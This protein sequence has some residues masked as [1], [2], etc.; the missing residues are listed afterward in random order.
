[1]FFLSQVSSAQI[2]FQKTYGGSGGGRYEQG[3]SVITTFDN[4]Y[5]MSGISQNNVDD[6]SDI[7][8]VKTDSIGSLLWTKRIGGIS[9]EVGKD[10]KQTGD[11]G[12]IITGYTYSYGAGNSDLF[13]LKTD[14]NG[15]TMWAKT[16]GGINSDNGNSVCQ[17][18][19]GGYIA[20]GTTASFGASNHSDVYIVKTD[21][22]G[23]TL[24]TRAY[25]GTYY[26]EGYSIQ[27]TADS[28]YI[29]SGFTFSFNEDIYLIK[30]NSSGNLL[31][32]RNIGGSNYDYGF[33]VKQTSDGGYIILGQTLSFGTVSD[34]YLVKT[35]SLGNLNWSKT[36]GG[37]YSAFGFTVEQT[38][39][40]GYIISGKWTDTH[41]FGCLIKTNVFGDTVWTRE[42]GI[43]GSQIYSSVKTHDNGYVASGAYSYGGRAYLL[44]T[45]AQGNSNC[46]EHYP[47]MTVSIPPTQQSTPNTIVSYTNTLVGYSPFQVSSLSN[48]FDICFSNN[49]IEFSETITQLI[50]YLSPYINSLTLSFS[51]LETS[52]LQLTLYDI[53]GRIILQQNITS[54]PGINKKE[55]PFGNLAQGVYVVTLSGAG[56]SMSRKVVKE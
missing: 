17:T 10:I 54:I 49:V 53:T 36:F 27:Q 6:S 1:M 35:N 41:D 14:I 40:M 9:N 5:V 7:Y 8:L 20:V 48:Q 30:I 12:F 3:Y 16:Y 34:I 33:V 29:I 21:S 42:Y 50:T 43:N 19:D 44:K 56:G 39:N 46:Y 25:G 28:G 52:N 18:F 26:D 15:D 51:S 55:I 4:G 37:T 38:Q 23:D 22:N 45:D 32:S 31:W 2:T 13:L 47:T 11:S 24:W